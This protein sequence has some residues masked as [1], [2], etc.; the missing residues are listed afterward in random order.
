MQPNGGGA[1][2]T[3]GM[4]PNDGGAWGSAAW[5]LGRDCVA[6]AHACQPSGTGSLVRARHGHGSDRPGA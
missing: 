1:H 2:R 5:P 4:R 3:R 6:R